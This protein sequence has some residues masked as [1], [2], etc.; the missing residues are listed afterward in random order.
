MF[1]LQGFI[2][3]RLFQRCVAA[4]NDVVVLVLMNTISAVSLSVGL[5]WDTYCWLMFWG[6]CILWLILLALFWVLTEANRHGIP[7][8]QFWNE[9]SPRPELL[10]VKLAILS[11]VFGFI[12]P[13]CWHFISIANRSNVKTWMEPF[14]H[15]EEMFCCWEAFMYFTFSFFACTNYLLSLFIE[16]SP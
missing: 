5:C 13:L 7:A 4:E 6:Q 2:T 10:T 15:L 11:N 9:P 1:T 8:E 12:D 14:P 16:D 3:L